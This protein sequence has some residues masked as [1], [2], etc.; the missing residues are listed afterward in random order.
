MDPNGA[1]Q[2]M[3]TDGPLDHFLPVWSP[4]SRK[5]AFGVWTGQ[6]NEIWVMDADG[7]HATM[8]TADSVY[9]LEGSGAGLSWSPS[10]WIAFVSDR[11][12]NPEIYAVQA[13]GTGLVRITDHPAKDFN[14]TW[15][16]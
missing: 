13:D 9:V 15:L 2:T 5:I 6:R 3:L 12:G 8:L 7:T 11:D 1:N 10:D 4:N 16:R 14:P